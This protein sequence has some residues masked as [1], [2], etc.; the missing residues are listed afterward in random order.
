MG[1]RVGG[2]SERPQEG[3]NLSMP[4][5]SNSLVLVGSGFPRRA[6]LVLAGKSKGWDEEG[7]VQMIYL[8]PW[9]CE[10]RGN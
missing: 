3:E 8:V 5:G 9:D 2:C 4:S 1:K 10:K 6:F 7:K